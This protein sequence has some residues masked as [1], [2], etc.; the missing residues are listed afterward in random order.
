MKKEEVEKWIA[1]TEE[2][3]EWIEGKKQPLLDK[4][5]ELLEEVAIYKKRLTDATDK[6][7]A[8]EEKLNGYLANLTSAHCIAVME[9]HGTTG[10]KV[11]NDKDLKSFVRNKIERLAEVDGGFKPVI[12][13]NGEFIYSTDAGKNFADYFAEWAK[14]EGAKPFIQNPCSGGGAGGSLS[15]S[16]ENPTDKIKHMTAEQVAKELDTPEFAKGFVK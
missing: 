8:L 10:E 15:Y 6:S 11:L 12:N 9:G 5:N 4:R 3:K 13:S 1:E 7:N 2:G 16:F 14:S